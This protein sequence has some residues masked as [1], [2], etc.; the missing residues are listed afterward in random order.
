MYENALQKWKLGKLLLADLRLN[1]A[2]NTP[3]FTFLT[4]YF[5]ATIGFVYLTWSELSNRRREREAGRRR[6]EG[7]GAAHRCRHARQNYG[8][9]HRQKSVRSLPRQALRVGRVW[10]NAGKK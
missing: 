7:G 9:G 1:F 4:T 5:T 10:Q 3:N 6:V 2:I 8:L